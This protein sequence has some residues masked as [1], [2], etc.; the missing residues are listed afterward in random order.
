MNYIKNLDVKN[1]TKVMN[2]TNAI[3]VFYPLLVVDLRNVLSSRQGWSRY[4]WG[5]GTNNH[6]LQ[7]TYKHAL[8]DS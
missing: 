8:R 5:G 7:P 4:P 6:Y 2:V 3:L 1:F